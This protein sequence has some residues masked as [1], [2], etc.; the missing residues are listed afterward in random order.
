M[1]EEILKLIDNKNDLNEIMTKPTIYFIQ[2]K[3]DIEILNLNSIL[4]IGINTFI[5]KKGKY[6]ERISVPDKYKNK[7]E[8]DFKNIRLDYIYDNLNIY[9]QEKNL[10]IE[11]IF[12][13]LNEYIIT[14]NNKYL[15]PICNGLL[16]VESKQTRGL[17]EP[18]T[19]KYVCS[20]NKKHTFNPYEIELKT[21]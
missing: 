4:E 17:D 7:Y 1:E 14:V 3:I 6:V 18:E 8:K 21:S 10:K 15:C 12:K 9:L 5:N 11:N 20:K 2:E 19:I 16:I 13:D